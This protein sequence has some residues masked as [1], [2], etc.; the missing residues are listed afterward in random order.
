MPRQKIYSSKGIFIVM[1]ELKKDEEEE[2]E[3]D[4]DFV[5]WCFSLCT[6]WTSRSPS[7]FIMNGKTTNVSS[8]IG[9]PHYLDLAFFSHPFGCFLSLFLISHYLI[10]ALTSSFVFLSL[11]HVYYFLQIISL[12]PTGQMCVC[13]SCACVLEKYWVFFISPTAACVLFTTYAL[14]PFF[15]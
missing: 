11:D 14:C 10:I 5:T 3:N 13:V 6:S 15:P 7:T 2:K 12:V 9:I 1:S 8:L 4:E